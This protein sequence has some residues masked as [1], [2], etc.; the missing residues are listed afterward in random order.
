MKSFGEM[1]KKIENPLRLE[2]GA[3]LKGFSLN[4]TNGGSV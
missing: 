2:L 4:L 3:D 1:A